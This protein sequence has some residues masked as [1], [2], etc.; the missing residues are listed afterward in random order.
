[1]AIISP[2]TDYLLLYGVVD[3]G[4]TLTWTGYGTSSGDLPINDVNEDGNLDIDEDFAGGTDILYT[5]YTINVGSETYGVFA[6]PGS[7]FVPYNSAFTDI[8]LTFPNSGSTSTIVDNAVLANYCF[9][10][11]T[12]ISTPDGERAIETLQIDD[13]VNTAD[14]RAVRV[15]WVGR[16]T[17]RNFAGAPP[18]LEPVRISAGALGHGLPHSDLTIS[19]DHGMVLDGMVINAAA[20]ANGS[21]IRFVPLSDL[22]ETFTWWHVETA[23]HAIIL[24]N[25]APSETFI[26]AA[27]RAAFDNHAE[28]LA[29]YGTHRILREM[30]LTR[31]TAARLLPDVLRTRLGVRDCMAVPETICA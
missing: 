2:M 16:Q 17:V 20:L 15:K 6:R 19:A 29:L 30:P 23:A 13:L 14:G 4:T 28:Y 27:G 18:R 22:A 21:T 11:G 26:D 25:G 3:N 24:A 12:L 7:Y 31:I 1:M 5:G 10:T 8:H 9:F